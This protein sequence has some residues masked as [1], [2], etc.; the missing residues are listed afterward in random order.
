MKQI[1]GLR[2]FSSILFGIAA[3]LFFGLVYPHH[4]HFQEQYQLF[5]FDTEY[6]CEVL[7]LPGGFADL[8]GRFCTQFFLFAWIGAIILGVLLSII[9]LLTARVFGCGRFYGMTFLPACLLWL[10]FLDENALL[11]S[12]WAVIITLLALWGWQKIQNHWAKI[13]TLVVAIPILYWAVG[14][15]CHLFFLGC[16]VSNRRYYAWAIAA[17]LVLLALPSWLQH[18]LSVPKTN[19]ING[20]HYYR[21]PNES[22]LMLKLAVFS[23]ILLIIVAW[24]E[25]KW[26]KQTKQLLLG[27]L[28]IAAV[29]I[30]QSVLLWQNYNPKAELVMGYD[31]MARHQQWNRLIGTAETQA[32]NN[33]VTMT[34]LNLAL[35]MRG[36]LAD[37]MFDY[38]QNGQAGLIPP[39]TSD[40]V[41]PLTTAETFYQLG[42]INSAQRFVFEAQEAI[43]D[44]Q[45]SARC[46]KR[47][48]ETNLING[49]YTVAGKYLNALQKTLF[50]SD[51]A[52]KTIKLL[53]DEETINKHPEYGRLRQ[54][55]IKEN[56]FFDERE[57]PRMLVS[58]LKSNPQN[59]LAYEYLQAAN[60][61]SGNVEDFILCFGLGRTL[62]Y[63][64]VPKHFQ[65][66][67][68]MWGS[69]NQGAKLPAQVS[70][71]IVQSMNRFTTLYQTP[72]MKREN[73]AKQFGNTYWYY[74]IT[75]RNQ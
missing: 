46:Y 18:H 30:A 1:L 75:K 7:A 50:Y 36:Q 15:I 12:L 69:Q 62:G 34:A 58:L 38:R 44:Y 6:V 26:G 68:A 28:S 31:Y 37:H 5:L 54:N 60:L 49:N 45:K 71:T 66:A 64:T 70:P 4:L 53:G 8:I 22:P 67:L 61:L 11:G 27:Y 20:I 19:L 59:R 24:M 10:F 48:A 47:L 35:G 2:A 16:L 3:T 33:A 17:M 57:I 9:Q 39:F 25:K 21:L 56:G 14:P 41:S 63:T 29:A 32:P 74:Y 23:F 55:A 51:W 72:G 65:E 43:P 42:L 40:A 52:D 73:L 13:I